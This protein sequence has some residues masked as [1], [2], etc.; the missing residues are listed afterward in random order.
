MKMITITIMI[1]TSSTFLVFQELRGN[2]MIITMIIL[3]VLTCF[4]SYNMWIVEAAKTPMGLPIPPVA[5]RLPHSSKYMFKYIYKHT[6][7]I[8]YFR[9]GCVMCLMRLVQLDL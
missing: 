6:Q 9:S 8:S 5:K 4:P 1:T 7:I 2:M 3:F